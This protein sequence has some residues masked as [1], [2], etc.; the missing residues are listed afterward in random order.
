MALVRKVSIILA[1][2]GS[3]IFLLWW[4]F[5]STEVGMLVYFIGGFFVFLAVPIGL[6]MISAVAVNFFKY[7]AVGMPEKDRRLFLSTLFFVVFNI[8]LAIMFASIA[9]PKSPFGD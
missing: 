9:I 4:F 7:Y 2:A 5:Q 6:L 8:P 3:S 1:L